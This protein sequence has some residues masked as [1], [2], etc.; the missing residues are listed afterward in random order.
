MSLRFIDQATNNGSTADAIRAYNYAKQ[1]RDLFVSSSGASGANIR[2]LNAS[3]GGGG[4]SKA[5]QD[6]LTALGNSGILF[7]AAAGND[8]RN[9]DAA[10]NYPSGYNLTNMI[11]VEATDQNDVRAS[12]SNFGAKSVLMGAPGVGILSTMPGNTYGVFSGTSMATPHVVGA[13]AL[14]CAANPNVNVNQLHALLAFNG[15]VIPALQ[16]TTLTGRRLN[17]FKSIQALNE[18]DITPPGTVGNFRVTSQTGRTVNLAWNAS[19]DDG[20]SGQASLY[21]ISF[22]DQSSGAVIPLTTLAPAASGLAANTQR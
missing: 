10:P 2:A 17:V 7:V 6:A 18:G 9:T 4:F 5:E 15:D 3:Y 20:A 21:D 13:A 11:S 12:F 1:M 14:V 16:G 22:T 19:G 8:G